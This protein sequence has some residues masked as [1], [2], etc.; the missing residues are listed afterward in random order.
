MKWL[1]L[2][3]IK[4]HLRI[5]ENYEDSLLQTYGESAEDLVLEYIN[6]TYDELLEEYTYV[7]TNIRHATLMLVDVFYK[8]RA[9]ISVENMNLV[10]YTF[11]MMLKPYM[12]L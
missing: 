8:Y 3:T 10:P 7:P 5:T 12:K 2:Q 11:D 1:D 9:P 6:S 4:D